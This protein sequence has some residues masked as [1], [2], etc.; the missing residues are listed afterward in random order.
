MRWTSIIC[1]IINFGSYYCYNDEVS[2]K[3][4]SKTITDYNYMRD[5]IQGEKYNFDGLNDD[6]NTQYIVTKKTQ[7]S[8]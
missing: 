5:K 4:D 6:K 1:T 7:Q 2:C 8:K 3:E